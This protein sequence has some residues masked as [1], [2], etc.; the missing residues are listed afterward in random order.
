MAK[1]ASIDEFAERLNFYAGSRREGLP[2]IR[3]LVL[4]RLEDGWSPAESE[5]EAMLLTTLLER[6]PSHPTI[7]CQAPLPWRSA[8]PGRVD[9]L[10]PGHRLIIEADGRRWH[11]RVADFDRDDGVTTRPTPRLP[12]LHFTWVHLR[13][14][15]DDSSTSSTRRS[16]SP[17]P[18]AS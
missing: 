5:L 1:K 12:R 13:D 16:P 7:V 10:I 3:P 4:E 8:S 6:V 18:S 9:V 17:W 15:A 11:T 14:L 2:K